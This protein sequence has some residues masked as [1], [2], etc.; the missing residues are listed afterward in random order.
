MSC[1]PIHA[2]LDNISDDCNTLSIY[3]YVSYYLQLIPRIQADILLH[4]DRNQ[5]D[6]AGRDIQLHQKGMVQS[7]CE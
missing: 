5:H 1:Y 2:E 7:L 3:T 6:Q 4:L